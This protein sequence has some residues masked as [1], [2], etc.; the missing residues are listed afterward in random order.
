[1]HRMKSGIVLLL[2]GLFL[3][4]LASPAIQ[5]KKKQVVKKEDTVVVPKIAANYGKYSFSFTTLDGKNVNLSDYAGKVVLVNIWAPWCGPCR[6]E[7]PGFV[8]LYSQYKNRGFAILGVAIQTNET[9]VRSFVQ[10]Q[11][12]SWPVGIKD[13]VAESFG[14]YGLPDNFLFKPDGSLVKHFVGYTQEEAVRPII[15]DALKGV[16]PSNVKTNT[17]N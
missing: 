9:D 11:K 17:G 2:A 3:V 6:G 12:I 16:A 7:T 1:M 8:K 14:T 5:K 13:A 10:Q 15:E 4:C